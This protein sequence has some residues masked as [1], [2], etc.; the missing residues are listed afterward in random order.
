MSN[1]RQRGQDTS[2]FDHFTG[3]EWNVEIHAYEESP[4]FKVEV[5]DGSLIH[6]GSK[7]HQSANDCLEVVT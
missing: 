5:F 3:N 2:I 6:V 4:T 1:R 7:K